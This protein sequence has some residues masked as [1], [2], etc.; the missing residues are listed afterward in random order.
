S[1]VDGEYAAAEGLLDGARSLLAGPAV[2]PAPIVGNAEQNTVKHT[3]QP[4]VSVGAARAVRRGVR[5]GLQCRSARGL[6]HGARIRGRRGRGAK[7]LQ[8]SP[9]EAV[10]VLQ[11]VL[12]EGAPRLCAPTE[13]HE[14]CRHPRQGQPF[15]ARHANLFS[16]AV[17]LARRICLWRML[18]GD[19]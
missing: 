11:A 13:E 19:K 3:A 5:E 9:R 10:V 7:K 18:D 14:A 2:E 17:G 4:P 8:A 15:G 12:A 16:A 6:V 1:R